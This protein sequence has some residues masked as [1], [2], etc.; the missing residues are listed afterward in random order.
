[1]PFLLFLP[2]INLIV[3]LASLAWAIFNIDAYLMAMSELVV[4]QLRADIS[5]SEVMP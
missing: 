1:L 5:S 2:C 4:E 3:A